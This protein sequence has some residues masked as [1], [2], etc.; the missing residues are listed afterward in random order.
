[1]WPHPEGVQQ[2]V[3]ELKVLHKSVGQT[4]RAGIAQTQQYLDCCGA[5]E[6]HLV[7]FD[8][9]PGKPWEEKLFHRTEPVEGSHIQVWGM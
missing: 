3:I 1:M 4:V 9:T 5:A 8:R 2:A 7:I 6:G